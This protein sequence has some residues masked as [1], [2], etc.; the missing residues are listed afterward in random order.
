MFIVRMWK[1]LCHCL[2]T[3]PDTSSDQCRG[4]ED[5]LRPGVLGKG[6]PPKR[7]SPRH[8]HPLQSPELD[9]LWPPLDPGLAEGKGELEPPPRRNIGFL[10]AF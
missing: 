5:R 1:I 9:S 10:F 2:L 7:N 6:A 3:V 4:R 8:S